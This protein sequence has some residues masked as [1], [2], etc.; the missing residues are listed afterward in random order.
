MDGGGA[1]GRARHAVPVRHPACTPAD[2]CRFR[3]RRDAWRLHRR[4]GDVRRLRVPACADAEGRPYRRRCVDG[5]LVLHRH[6]GG[7]LFGALRSGARHRQVLRSGGTGAGRPGGDHGHRLRR[8]DVRAAG[9]SSHSPRVPHADARR[10]RRRRRLGHPW[11]RAGR[12]GMGRVGACLAGRCMAPLQCPAAGGG[13]ALAAALRLRALVFPRVL[14][15]WMEAPHV[16]VRECGLLPRLFAGHRQGV[17]LRVRR[18]LHARAVVGGASAAGRRGGD[19]QRQLPA[20]RASAGRQR[21]LA[22]GLRPADPA[23]A[24][25]ADPHAWSFGG[26]RRPIVRVVLGA[27]WTC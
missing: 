4:L 19:D 23:V 3:P 24:G 7:L 21:R 18:H 6:G 10:R 2:A 27:Q 8:G 25:V 1:R 13:R 15:L 20:A 9:A 17:R 22:P 26:L 12:P 5:V 14:L 16:V 11:R